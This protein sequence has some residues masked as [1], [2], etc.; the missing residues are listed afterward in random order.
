MR[1]LPRS[2]WQPHAGTAVCLGLA[3]PSWHYAR[4]LRLWS[5]Q[6]GRKPTYLHRSIRVD[7]R[8]PKHLLWNE[9]PNLATKVDRNT[10]AAPVDH[11]PLQRAVAEYTDEQAEPR[12]CSPKCQHLPQPL[13]SAAETCRLRSASAASQEEQQQQLYL[14]GSYSLGRHTDPEVFEHASIMIFI[15]DVALNLLLA[16]QA[17]EC[18][19]WEPHQNS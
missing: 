10:S 5:N 12:L 17:A 15:S 6:K 11:P 7:H 2:N 9:F 13:S 3:P 1:V 19:C 14:D 4:A 18:L 8:T 16:W